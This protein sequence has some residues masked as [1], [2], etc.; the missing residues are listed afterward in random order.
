MIL[1]YDDFFFKYTGKNKYFLGI[2]YDIINSYSLVEGAKLTFVPTAVTAASEWR[3][4]LCGR[5]RN[6]L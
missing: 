1:P 6:M 2:F 3:V 5:E 4:E